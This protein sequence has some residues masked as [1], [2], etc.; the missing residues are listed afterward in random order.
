MYQ[1]V[2]TPW[3]RDAIETPAKSQ[4]RI[5]GAGYEISISLAVKNIISDRMVATDAHP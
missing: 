5:R 3:E 1:I 2:A 4:Q